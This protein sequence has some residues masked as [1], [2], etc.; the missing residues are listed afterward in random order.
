[1]LGLL[2]AL[3]EGIQNG[4]EDMENSMVVPQK[5]KYIIAI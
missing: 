2:C 4:A 1:M 5:I 3:L